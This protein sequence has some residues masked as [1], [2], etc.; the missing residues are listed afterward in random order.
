MHLIK[1]E[2]YIVNRDVLLSKLIDILPNGND[3]L[4]NSYKYDNDS[5]KINILEYKK[6]T[7]NL[8]INL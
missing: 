5:Y 8:D 3:M 7:V 4:S 2:F 6:G 1:K